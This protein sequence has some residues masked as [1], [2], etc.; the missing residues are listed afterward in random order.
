MKF[1]KKPKVVNITGEA[2]E[3]ALLKV[4]RFLGVLRIVNGLVK[5][6]EL[7]TTRNEKKAVVVRELCGKIQDI[8]AENLKDGV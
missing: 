8:L 6:I 1:N 2:L 7:N 3:L 4:N 5:A